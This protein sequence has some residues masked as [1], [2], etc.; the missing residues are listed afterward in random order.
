M[1]LVLA[2]PLAIILWAFPPAA[3]RALGVGMPVVATQWP[4]LT[5]AVAAT[6]LQAAAL[7]LWPAPALFDRALE[8]ENW[9][10]AQHL[11]FLIT[12]LLFG[13]RCCS[14]GRR[15]ELRPCA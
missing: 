9:H 1:L 13:P 3:R 2:E 4:R 5:G 10:V 15:R 7:W 6:V 12:A 14:G 8:S 11:S